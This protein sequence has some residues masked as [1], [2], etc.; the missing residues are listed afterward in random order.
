LV[1]KRA[2]HR[3]SQSAV[4][5]KGIPSGGSGRV[6]HG[7]H[8]LPAEVDPAQEGMRIDVVFGA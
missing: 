6:L 4:I 8:R 2:F 1:V 7:H 5:A 3:F